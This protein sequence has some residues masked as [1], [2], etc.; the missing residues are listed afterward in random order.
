MAGI[1]NIKNIKSIKINKENIL[2]N[3]EE[4]KS[5]F[6]TL[7]KTTNTSIDTGTNLISKLPI[8]KMADLQDEKE[9]I[10]DLGG[11]NRYV[12]NN[13][14]T[15][16]LLGAVGGAS[17]GVKLPLVHNFGD[18]FTNNETLSGAIDYGLMGLGFLGGGYLG[19]KLGK[20]F[21]ETLSKKTIETLKQERKL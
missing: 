14:A 15:Y 20:S 21:G 16:K 19:S 18:D 13:K 1:K 3:L 11:P 7:N 6:N 2:K 5:I 4:S 9:L 10:K 17:A 8:E 12:A